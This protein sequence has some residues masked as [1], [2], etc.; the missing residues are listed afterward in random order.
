MEERKINKKRRINF[1]EFVSVEVT[2]VILIRMNEP[3]MKL[4]AQAFIN[5]M[6]ED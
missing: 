1:E 2:N 3:N 5:L 4:M 6:K